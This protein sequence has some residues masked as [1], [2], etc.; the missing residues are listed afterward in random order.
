MGQKKYGFNQALASAIAVASLFTAA[1]AVANGPPRGADVD[2]LAGNCNIGTFPQ[3]SKAGSYNN[4]CD[5]MSDA[6]KC[7]G[8]LKQHFNYNG[9]TRVTHEPQILAYCLEELGDVLNPPAGP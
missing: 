9:T 6:E 7:L 2:E 3:T 5:Q 4:L 8:L 1:S